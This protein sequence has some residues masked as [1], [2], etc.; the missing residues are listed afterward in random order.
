[1]PILTQQKD[2]PTKKEIENIKKN[3]SNAINSSNSNKI[4]TSDKSIS[5]KKED[6]QSKNTFINSIEIKP[7]NSNTEESSDNPSSNKNISNINNSNIKPNVYAPKRLTS[8]F[9][10]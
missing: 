3:I 8:H 10:K 2:S 5:N 9:S 1:M 4:K 6:Y 7:F